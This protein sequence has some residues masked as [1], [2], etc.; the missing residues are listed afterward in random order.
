MVLKPPPTPL[1]PTVTAAVLVGMIRAALCSLPDRRKGGNNQRYA[2]GD[3]GLSAFSVFFLQ[4]PS[5]LDYQRRMQKEHGRNNAGS[6]FGVHQIPST[7]QIGNLLDAVAP[8]HLAPVFIDLVGALEA[9]GEVAAHRVLDG[10][11]LVALDGTQYHSSE[12]I[13]CPQCAD[14]VLPRGAHPDAR[15]A[16]SGGSVPVAPGVRPAP[17]RGGQTGLRAQRRHTLAAAVGGAPRGVA[18]HRTG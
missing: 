9:G 12:A 15:R 16:G 10:R 11:L 6:L 5:F 3:A 18:Y 13:H 7:Q 14:P 8:A 4:S 17:G 1:R 2:M